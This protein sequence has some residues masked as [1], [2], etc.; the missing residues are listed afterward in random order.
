[1]TRRES[2]VTVREVFI[3]WVQS[4]PQLD[5][6]EPHAVVDLARDGIEIEA[7]VVFPPTDTCQFLGNAWLWGVGGA[8][9]Q[10]NVGTHIL[11]EALDDGPR[12]ITVVLAASDASGLSNA[13]TVSRSLIDSIVLRH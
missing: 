11:F 9:W 6:S 10:P 7:T 3:N 5:A 8:A 13:E 12:T 1:M 4:A 2:L